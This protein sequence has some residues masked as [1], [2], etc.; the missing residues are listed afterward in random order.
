MHS[1]KASEGRHDARDPAL[2][3]ESF[4]ICVRQPGMRALQSI[5][6]REYRGSMQA[7]PAGRFPPYWRRSLNDLLNAYHRICSYLCLYIPRATGARSVDHMVPKSTAWNQACEWSNYRLACSLMNARKGDVAAVLDP[8]DVEDGW[9]ALELVGFQ[10]LPGE[11][12]ATRDFATVTETIRCLR[13]NDQ[14][15]CLARAEY[16]EAY[17]CKEI[18]IDYMRRHAPFVASELCRQNRLLGADRD[19]CGSQTGSSSSERT[20]SSD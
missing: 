4:D 7:I 1:L 20:C 17:W 11:G 2:E 3:P 8:F 6:T 10:V 15:C 13:L 9:F 16:A 19:N 5:A 12:L 14:E 18:T